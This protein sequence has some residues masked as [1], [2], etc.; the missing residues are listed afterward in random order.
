M[1]AFFSQ[2]SFLF[3]FIRH[4]CFAKLVYLVLDD[5]IGKWGLCMDVNIDARILAGEAG[6][7]G[8]EGGS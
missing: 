7:S 5:V 8:G 6:S 2:K 3:A 4:G 1:C